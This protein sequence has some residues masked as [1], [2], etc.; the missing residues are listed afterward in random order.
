MEVQNRRQFPRWQINRPAKVQLEGAVVFAPC[1]VKDINFKGLTIALKI[2]LRRD[3]Y[4]KFKLALSDEHIIDVE[5][6]LVWHK[7]VAGINIY[8]LYFTKISEQDKE[9]IYKFV[10]KYSTQ[11]IGKDQRQETA[12]TEK[13]GGEEVDDRRIFERFSIRFP[14]KF[15]DVATGT[16]GLAQTNDISAKGIGLRTSFALQARTPL[17]IWLEVPDKGEPLYTRGQVVWAKPE[18]QNEYRAGINLEKADLMG[19]SRILRA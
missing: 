12:I 6:W 19:L 16:E 3:A 10:H 15:L 17:E 14:V 7:S 2:R 1:E 9:K 18:G 11:E 5:S 13:R 4:I 8:G